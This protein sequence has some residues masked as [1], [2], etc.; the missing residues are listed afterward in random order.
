MRQTT[1]RGHECDRALLLTQLLTLHD[2]LAEEAL[3]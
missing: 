3:Q 2:A 1:K